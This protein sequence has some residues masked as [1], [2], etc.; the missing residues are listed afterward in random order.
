MYI[1][2]D[3]DKDSENEAASSSDQVVQSPGRN[4]SADRIY[5]E[6]FHS[7]SH[8]SV[9]T[10]EDVPQGVIRNVDPPVRRTK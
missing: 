5:N 10:G 4:Q 8:V 1:S 7:S 2:V 3:V 9:T 6:A